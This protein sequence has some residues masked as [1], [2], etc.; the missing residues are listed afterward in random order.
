MHLI[1]HNMTIKIQEVPLTGLQQWSS[2]SFHHRMAFR[3]RTNW[4]C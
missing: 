3:E 4:R 1:L 2:A